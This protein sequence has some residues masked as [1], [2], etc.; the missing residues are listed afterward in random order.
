[1]NKKTYPRCRF[2][3]SFREKDVARIAGSTKEETRNLLVTL[4]KPSPCLRLMP[5]CKEAPRL[6]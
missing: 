4:S 3:S 6:Q 5:Y 2:C 1:M